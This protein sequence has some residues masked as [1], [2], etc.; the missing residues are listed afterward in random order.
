MAKLLGIKSVAENVDNEAVV[1]KLNTIGIDYAQ[2]FHLGDLL[3][4]DDLS[5]DVQD[6]G[7]CE[8]QLN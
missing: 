1:E 8:K 6:L 2:G 4:L 5:S 7:V 3:R